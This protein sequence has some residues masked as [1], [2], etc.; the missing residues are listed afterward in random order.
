MRRTME[1]SISRAR[2]G[3]VVHDPGYKVVTREKSRASE[4]RVSGQLTK[5]MMT[6]CIVQRC[7]QS[8]SLNIN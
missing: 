7:L 6:M 3:E 2:K 1:L 8:D 4:K 5:I